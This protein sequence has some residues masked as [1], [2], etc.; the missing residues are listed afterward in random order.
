MR[1]CQGNEVKDLGEKVL[2][3]RG[4]GGLGFAK[5]TVAPVKNLMAVNS[6]VRMG[7]KV[8]FEPG[9]AYYQHVKT[10]TVTPLEENNGVYEV[11]FELEPFGSAPRAPPRG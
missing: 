3:L 8:V 6:L 1:D 2:A 7:H 11:E 9:G 5:V 4:K 10:G